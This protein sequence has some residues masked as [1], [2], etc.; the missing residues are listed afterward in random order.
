M[1]ERWVVSL[2]AGLLASCSTPSPAT[3]ES[4]ITEDVGIAQ[5]PVLS[6]DGTT[7]AFAS[8]ADNASNLQIWIRRVDK[9]TAASRLTD[10]AS[11]NYDPEFSADGK[12]VYFTSTREPQGI[13]RAPVNGG[14]PELVVG[15]SVAAKISPD[16]KTLLY[17]NEGKVLLRALE[18]GPATELL[19][20]IDNSYAPVFSADG[21]RILVTGKN[22]DEHDP[23]WWIAQAA[24][25]PRKTSIAADLRQQGFNSV[26]VNAWLPG[27]WIV[28]T[29]RQDQTQTLWKIQIGPD[30]K[31]LGKAV[32]AT[33]DA[34]GDYGASFAAGKMVFARTQVDMNLWALPLDPSGERLAGSPERLTNSSARKGQE[35]AGG[36]KLLYSGENGDR[37]SLYM[38]DGQ[39]EKL[40]GDG[41]YSVLTPDGSRYAYGEGTKE[42]LRVSSKAT[43]W[44][45]F[46][47]SLLCE[48]CGMPRGFSQD[49]TKLLL[50]SDSPPMHHVDLL[51]VRSRQIDR[52]VWAGQDLSGPR[53]S[54]DGRWVSF[55]AKGGGHEWRT[56]VAPVSQ[57]K[58]VSSFEWVPITPVSDS[59]HFAFWSAT[60]DVMYILTARGGSG[61]LR[62]LEAQKL[63]AATKR[64]IGGL[65]PVHEFDEMLVP[66]MD[67]IWNT[68]SV[69]G[70]R[71][72]LELGGVSTNIWIK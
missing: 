3:D 29:G 26:S 27:D 43:G 52:I 57:S 56:F 55:V 7:I 18:G 66:G 5:S 42:Q 24:G 4:Q 31:T 23:E 53:L 15:D 60:G 39:K 2:V 40:L 63:D 22:R 19:P 65:I 47:S 70:N 37:F 20:A 35:S 46:W 34:E 41:F 30:G 69:S 17:G 8:K 48:N 51:D 33:R 10:G 11:S 61:N 32:R 71:I 50:W 12:S 62:W 25:E 14:A 36:A 16:G 54:P 44:W 64:P 38:K 68:V 67:P 6:K 28:F 1:R 72:V 13:Y 59:F 49:G 45:P 21:A 58:P 9:T